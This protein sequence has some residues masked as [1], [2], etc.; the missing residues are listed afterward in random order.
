MKK[1]IALLFCFILV[2]SIAGCSGTEKTFF[3]DW[4]I[5]SKLQDAPIGDINEEDLSTI[6]GSTL[7][8][9]TEK[10]SCFGDSLDTLGQTVSNPE[11]TT[12]DI[13]KSEFESMIG[14]SFEKIGKS[15]DNIRQISVV[16]DPDKNSGIV[17]YIV[18]DNTLLANS[19]G[20]FFILKK[21]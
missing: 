7:S 6:L 13:E 19:V 11:Y 4:T 16:K 9:T 20:T 8:F 12:I 21:K 2:L 10:A 5:D 1:I 17:F 15:G 14:E 18:D 3:G